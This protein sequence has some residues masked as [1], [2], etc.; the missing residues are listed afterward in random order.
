MVLLAAFVDF[1]AELSLDGTATTF[2]E[3]AKGSSMGTDGVALADV[4]G[5][6]EAGFAGPVS[7]WF[8]MGAGCASISAGGIFALSL[9]IL[10][11]VK[12][13][14]LTPKYNK[15]MAIN[16]TKGIIIWP[17]EKTGLFSPCRSLFIMRL[18]PLK[19]ILYLKI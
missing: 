1:A 17:K 3:L 11:G 13:N 18:S 10:V 14:I 15:P 2:L 16:P 19:L 12:K 5:A 7:A 4:P 6:F 8:D 9:T